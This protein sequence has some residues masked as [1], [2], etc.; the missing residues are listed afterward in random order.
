MRRSLSIPILTLGLVSMGWNSGLHGQQQQ[1]ASNSDAPVP[2][3]PSAQQPAK[4]CSGQ[5]Q[6]GAKGPAKT[7]STCPPPAQ[8][9]DTTPALTT[10]DASPQQ[11]KKSTAEDNPFPEDVSRKA[12]DAAKARDAEEA[13]PA[14]SADRNADESS[15]RDKLENLD[16]LG[17]RQDR[18]SDGAGGTI[19]DPKL[20]AN[21]VQVGQFYLNREDYK[22]AYARFKE[23]TKVDPGNSDAVFY[24]AEAARKMNQTP[25]AVENYQ[26]YLDAVPDGS[27]AKDA[28]KALRDLNASAKH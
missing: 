24:L 23:A 3:S 27:K 6:W 9:N 1:P 20:A 4:N 19:F 10:K 25:E 16:L 15:S 18:T 12:E 2:P 26:L 5:V 28:R 11:Q 17:D 8:N 13:K 21:D 22:G 14:S 7:S